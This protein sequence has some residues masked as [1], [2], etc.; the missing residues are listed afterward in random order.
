MII[1]RLVIINYNKN[2]IGSIEIRPT[3]KR[4]IKFVDYEFETY[5]HSLFFFALS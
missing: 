1:I 2:K 4:L 3:N 5:S